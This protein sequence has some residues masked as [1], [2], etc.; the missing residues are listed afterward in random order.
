MPFVEY[1]A[2]CNYVVAT[3]SAMRNGVLLPFR[4]AVS[5]KRIVKLWYFKNYAYLCTRV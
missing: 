1:L 4:A 2:V 3:F 5:K